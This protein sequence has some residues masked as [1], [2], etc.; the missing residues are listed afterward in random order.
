MQQCQAWQCNCAVQHYKL[1]VRILEW[2]II[3]TVIYK[4]KH[5]DKDWLVQDLIHWND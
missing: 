3:H 1:D 2:I 4:W 5:V